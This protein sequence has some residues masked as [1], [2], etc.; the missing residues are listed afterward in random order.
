[1][2]NTPVRLALLSAALFLIGCP[3]PKDECKI[4]TDCATGQICSANKCVATNMG[5]GIGG[6]TTTGGGTAT[7]GG[8]GGGGGLVTGCNIGSQNC[9][10]GESCM[11]TNTM[12]ATACFPGTCD[13]VTQNCPTASDKCSYAA[14]PDGGTGRVCAPAGNI[15]EGGA[16]GAGADLCA[17]GLV[18]INGTCSKYCYQTSNC[19]AA[20]NGQ[21][22]GVVQIGGTAELPT[23]CINIAS[24]DPLLQNCPM[25]AEACSL[26]QSGPGCIP[27]GNVAIGADCRMGNCVKGAACLGTQAA[28]SCRPFC[29]LDGGMPTC[30][31][32][33]CGGLRDSNMVVQPFGACQ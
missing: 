23:T 26:T 3:G 18:C 13:V 21:C 10:P 15:G 29:N 5:G 30:A 12:G 22:V 11:L 4:N 2:K 9:Q 17:K 8:T 7:G 32:G 24:C 27:A 19:T 16:C 33:A 20:T 14:L 1:M 28:A 25:A 6:G 31:S